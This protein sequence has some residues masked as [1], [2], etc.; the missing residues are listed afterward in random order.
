MG[1][2]DPPSDAIWAAGGVVTR[3]R[4]DGR[5]EYLIVHRP[6]Y[7]DWS[8]PKGKLDNGEGF[9]AAA[10]R[11]V[12]EETGFEVVSLAKLGAIGYDTPAGNSKVV[13]Y[14]LFEAERGRFI[15]NP[16]VD[17]VAW[18][19]PNKA[20][21]RLTYS[22]DRALVRWAASL[23][24]H[25]DAARVHLVRHAVAGSRKCSD[26]DD[27][28]RPLTEPGRK[29][30]AAISKLLMKTPLTHAYTSTHA[31]CEQTLQ[32]LGR[33]LGIEIETEPSLI[34]AVPPEH[35]VNRMRTIKGRAVAMSS[36][37]DVIS[38]VV[39]MLMADGVDLDGGLQWEKGSIWHFDLRKGRVT[40]GAYL[41][42]P[43]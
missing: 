32:P 33:A 9:K 8:L 23:T 16:E 17:E 34:E 38:G 30:A 40:S 5:H 18:V 13:R 36:H 28:D 11:E 6:R 1:F 3:R 15:P 19:R 37:G 41:P 14:W 12:A 20:D 42:P 24:N 10:K 22:R 25:P 35:L 2:V 43:L 7:D 31:R 27:R 21:E 29:Q 26:G 39:G 4:S